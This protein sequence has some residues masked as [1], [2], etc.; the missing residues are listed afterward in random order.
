PTATPPEEPVRAESRNEP[1]ATPPEE[2]VR[3]ESRNEPTA[4]P[5]EEPVRTESR[6]EP[7]TP[8]AGA[9]ARTDEPAPRTTPR[10]ET[11]TAPDEAGAPGPPSGP[12]NAPAPAGKPGISPGAAW[13]GVRDVIEENH[14]SLFA[15]LDRCALKNVTAEALEIEVNGNDFAVGMIQRAKNMAILKQVCAESF[16]REMDL[17][18]HTPKRN[19]DEQQEKRRRKERLKKSALSHPLVSDAIEIF[20]GKVLDVKILQEVDQ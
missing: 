5:P 17:V 16:G 7:T 20:N 18:I 2:P 6:N 9:S 19:N 12:A 1:T 15:A 8:P 11:P 4:T 10:P 14:P 3:A 13:R